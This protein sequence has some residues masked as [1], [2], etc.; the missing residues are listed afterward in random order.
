MDG[1]NVSLIFS[2]NVTGDFHPLRGPTLESHP[3]T[4][5]IR[6]VGSNGRVLAEDLV[7]LPD[8]VCVHGGLGEE[9][10]SEPFDGPHFFDTRFPILAEADRLEIWR[11]VQAEPELEQTL[12]LTFPF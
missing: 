10:T 4:V 3:G 11:I 9:I 12:L 6:V 5:A 8:H 2:R 7:D 1:D